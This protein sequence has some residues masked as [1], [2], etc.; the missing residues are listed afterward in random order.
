MFLFFHTAHTDTLDLSWPITSRFGPKLLSYFYLDVSCLLILK[1]FDLHHRINPWCVFVTQRYVSLA[2]RIIGLFVSTYTLQFKMFNTLLLF[3]KIFVLQR[4]YLIV[5]Y[6]QPVFI[7][8][9]LNHPTYYSPLYYFQIFK[10]FIYSVLWYLLKHYVFF[11][12]L[13]LTLTLFSSIYFHVCGVQNKLQIYKSNRVTIICVSLIFQRHNIMFLILFF[14]L[15]HRFVCYKLDLQSIIIQTLQSCLTCI[16]TIN[17]LDF[18]TCSYAVHICPNVT[19]RLSIA[20][21]IS[22]LRFQISP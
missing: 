18:V 22:S 13:E 11:C 10:A 1:K 2:Y 20:F 12:R 4:I 8:L 7:F 14:N 9:P 16:A 21:H 15:I 6:I 17:S 5:V 3:Q 19:H